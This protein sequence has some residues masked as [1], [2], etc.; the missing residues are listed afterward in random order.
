[1]SACG[2]SKLT[3]RSAGSISHSIFRVDC[4]N[5]LLVI[6]QQSESHAIDMMAKH[7]ALVS[8]QDMLRSGHT[9]D[10]L[11]LGWPSAALD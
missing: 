7:A 8:W 5:N 9:G 11:G 2:F 1:M 6:L 3:H 10:V 4:S